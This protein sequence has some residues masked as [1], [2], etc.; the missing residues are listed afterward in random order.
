MLTG[1]VHL[2]FIER[3]YH[4]YINIYGC[5]TLLKIKCIG[6]QKCSVINDHPFLCSL[7]V[8]VLGLAI[9]FFGTNLVLKQNHPHPIPVPKKFIILWNLTIYVLMVFMCLKA[10]KAC[11]KKCGPKRF[12]YW[13]FSAPMLLLNHPEKRTI[14]YFYIPTIF[15][16]HKLIKF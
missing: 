6:W 3:C 1:A 16:M 2:I 4:R 9:D 7:S 5:Y 10:W 15:K 13:K 14:L 11:Y 8:Y 12:Q